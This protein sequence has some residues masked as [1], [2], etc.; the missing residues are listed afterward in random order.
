MLLINCTPLPDE[1][2]YILN[3]SVIIDG[4]HIPK[5]FKWNGASIPFFLW[6]ILGGPF[7]PKFMAP[8]L[9][10]DYLY[11]SGESSGFS[12]RAADKLFRKHL[13]V[14]GVSKEDADTLYFGVR[15]AGKPFWGSWAGRDNI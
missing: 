4:V 3:T 1:N 12:R 8:S 5:G 7:S 10:H 9:L 15:M 13:L 11:S 6:P 14:N 2:C